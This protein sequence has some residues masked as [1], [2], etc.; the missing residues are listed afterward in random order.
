M[1]QTQNTTWN[2]AAIFQFTQICCLPLL[3]YLRHALQILFI[4]FHDNTDRFSMKKD[5]HNSK[6]WLQTQACFWL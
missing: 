5:H 6:I 2:M 3:S 4:L 1:F